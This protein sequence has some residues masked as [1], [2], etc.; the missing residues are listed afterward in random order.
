M[1]LI[2]IIKD[3]HYIIVDDSKIKEGDYRV[4]TKIV[5]EY[6]EQAIAYVD[7]EQLAII[8]EIGGAK[9]IIYSTQPLESATITDDI[10]HKR[11]IQIKYL[12]ILEVQELIYGYSVENMASNYV[13]SIRNR[14]DGYCYLDIQEG[15]QIGFNAHKELVKDKN[16]EVIELLTNIT[17]WNSFKE[18]PIGKQAQRALDLI[19]LKTEWEVTFDEQGKLQLI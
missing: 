13:D 19:L 9:K 2:E 7:K 14:I 17:E 10:E 16:K 1:K 3:K 18:H 12:D 4:A 15:Y 6:G 5:K 11:F 8:K